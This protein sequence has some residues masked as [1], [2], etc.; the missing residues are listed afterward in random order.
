MDFDDVND[1]GE[2]DFYLWLDELCSDLVA[3]E[4][5]CVELLYSVYFFWLRLTLFYWCFAVMDLAWMIEP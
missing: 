4:L 3:F 2:F 1:D 5:L